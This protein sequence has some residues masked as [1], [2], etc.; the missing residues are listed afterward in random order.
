VVKCHEK[1]NN[2]CDQGVEVG[3]DA[4]VDDEPVIASGL[5]F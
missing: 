5:S 1:R 2:G 3:V 4:A